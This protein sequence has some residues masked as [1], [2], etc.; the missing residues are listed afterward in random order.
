M[1]RHSVIAACIALFAFAT[2][3]LH[4]QNSQDFDA[5]R[6]R[7]SALPTDQL[8]PD[9]AREYGISRS[10]QRGLLN[11][12]VQRNNAGS[13]SDPIHATLAGSA[14]TLGGQRVALKFREIAEDGAVYYISEF[15]VSPPDTYRFEIKVT[16]ESATAP[17]TLRFNKDFVAD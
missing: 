17:Y 10:R 9:V 14:T 13:V 1:R 8:L 6:V 12:A 16:P 4:A 3:S 11:I 2:S 15:P 7:Y 5:Y